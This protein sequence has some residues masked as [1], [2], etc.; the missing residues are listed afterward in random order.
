MREREWGMREW[1]CGY[2][3]TGMG[4]GGI[5]GMWVWGFKERECE[6]GEMENGECDYGGMGNERMGMWVWGSQ[7]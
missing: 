2:E 4:N 7:P 6:Y 5:I 3:R 1:E